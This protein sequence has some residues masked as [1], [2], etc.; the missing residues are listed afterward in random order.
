[1]SIDK[2]LTLDDLQRS[3]DLV[4]KIRDAHPVDEKNLQIIRDGLT[5][6]A[7]IHKS[8]LL[9]DPDMVYWVEGCDLWN[10]APVIVGSPIAV[11]KFRKMISEIREDRPLMRTLTH[12]L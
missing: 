10:T 8:E 3:A 12:A 6:R 2:D 7:S 9:S 5:G 11:K 1:M 4:Q